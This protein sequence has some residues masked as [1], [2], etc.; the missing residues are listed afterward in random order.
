M[1]DDWKYRLMAYF[2]LL[3]ILI[4]C[5]TI[6]S[7][8]TLFISNL[9]GKFYFFASSIIDFFILI[10][11]IIII[12]K[13]RKI[14][15]IKYYGLSLDKKW[16][17]YFTRAFFY[18][19]I[20]FIILLISLKI[21]GFVE[22]NQSFELSINIVLQIVVLFIFALQEEIIFRGFV[23]NTLSTKF[24]EITTIVLSALFFSFVHSMN[25]NYT[26]LPSINTFFA[27][28]L[29]GF[30]YYRTRSLWLPVFYHFFWNLFQALILGSNISGNTSEVKLFIANYD[31]TFLR[32]L[33]GDEYGF[34]SSIICT[35]I[36]LIIFFLVKNI[37]T[38]NVENSSYQYNVKY[39]SDRILVK[40]DNK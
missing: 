10:T 23:Q 14:N 2:S 33:L 12:E 18:S 39:F 30:M 35:L 25:S 34:E 19:S 32:I 24:S 20:P 7:D 40:N 17:G 11:P 29:L 13:F 1:V 38:L 3:I 28:L 36:L 9:F 4:L 27:G 21:S 5:V 16:F 37:E 31:S 8:I 6:L 26:L 22:V 15:W